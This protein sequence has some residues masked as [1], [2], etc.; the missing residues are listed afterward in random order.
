MTFRSCPQVD[1]ADGD[2]QLEAVPNR[3]QA[4]GLDAVVRLQCFAQR[5][6]KFVFA[7]I[8]LLRSRCL[9]RARSSREIATGAGGAGARPSTVTSPVEFKVSRRTR[10]N[11]E[12]PA[13]FG[14]RDCA[15]GN[16]PVP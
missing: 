13:L 3:L 2:L 1:S 5:S 4:I 16:S 8:R 10:P 12:V 7:R 9:L 11:V 14:G 6:S 15:G